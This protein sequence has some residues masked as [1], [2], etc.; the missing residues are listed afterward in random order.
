VKI[1]PNPFATYIALEQAEEVSAVRIFSLEGREVL[2]LEGNAN[3][4]YTLDELTPG[5][6]VLALEDKNG[7]V[8]QASEITKN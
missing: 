3:G 5:V 8:F 6:Y 1:F 4:V 7:R 2:R